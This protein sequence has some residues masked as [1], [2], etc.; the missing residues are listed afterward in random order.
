MNNADQRR[1]PDTEQVGKPN[2]G[3]TPSAGSEN[4]LPIGTRL[5][6]FE[7]T[8][9]IGEGGFG[10]VYLAFDHSL[11]RTV[12]IKEYMPAALASRGTDQ[13]I[14]VRAKR[15]EEAFAAGLRSFINEAR[16]LAQFD[17]SALIKVYRFWEQNKTAYMAMRYYEGQTFKSLVKAHPEMVNESWLKQILKPILEALDALYRVNILHRDISPENIM[18]RPNGEAVLL[19]FGA[20]RQIVT[21]LTKSLT[22]IL[23]PGYAPVEQYADDESMKQGPWTD[24][25]SLSAVMYSAIAKKPP[26]TAVTRMLSDPIVPLQSG[27][28]AGFGKDF[29]AAVD[30]GLAVRPEDRPQSIAEF[31]QLLGIDMSA[32]SHAEAVVRPF[33][34][35]PAPARQ[36]SATVPAASPGKARKPLWPAAA[37]GIALVMAGG[38]WLA[39]RHDAAHDQ[40]PA[41]VDVPAIAATSQAAQTASAQQDSQPKDLSLV[42][43]TAS[44]ES[45]V[46][47]TTPDAAQTADA[48]PPKPAERKKAKVQDASA[49]HA[50]DAHKGTDD[51]AAK[52][53]GSVA[54]MIKP[55]GN[56]FV[57]GEPKGVSPPLK[58][59]SLPEGRHYVRVVN[60]NFPEYVVNV[61][62]SANK[63]AVVN[64]DFAG[65]A[66]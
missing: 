7:I 57:D 15:H 60:P 48:I 23:K 16:L 2:A 55:W 53:I 62:V 6:E 51:D 35:A 52:P 38:L 10:I 27:D 50:A 41:S 5:A 61:S 43:N 17:H 14:A 24:I 1:T 30:R 42:N 39:T 12:A 54:L 64:R 13:S 8:S 47:A 40:L 45:V 26:P 32:P 21:G 46:P 44:A 59:L 33:P 36:E 65:S 29:L 25:Y 34:P 31:A 66:P 58:K 28:H 4:C 22:V 3:D 20:A 49:H 56:V 19:D 37:V 9:V 63:P 18:I 11:Q